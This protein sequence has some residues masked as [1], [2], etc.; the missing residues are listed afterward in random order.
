MRF[1][2]SSVLQCYCQYKLTGYISPDATKHAA[3][4]EIPI[5]STIE[6]VLTLPQA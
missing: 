1:R 6:E 4:A 5:P 3:I 2:A